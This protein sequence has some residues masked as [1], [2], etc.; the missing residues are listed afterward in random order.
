MSN[1]H[2]EEKDMYLVGLVEKKIVEGMT[3]CMSVPEIA[4]Q[5]VSQLACADENAQAKRYKM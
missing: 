5:I 2:L 4:R 1:S 3:Q